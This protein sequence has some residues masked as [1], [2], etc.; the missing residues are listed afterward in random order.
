MVY[1]NHMHEYHPQT[2]S[3]PALQG[4]SQKNIEEH[5]KLYHGYVTHANL[6]TKRIHE[7][8]ERAEDFVYEIAEL[9]RRFGFEYNGMRN[10]EYYFTTFE[11]GAQSFVE[12]S[13]LKQALVE[14][15]GSYEAWLARFKA[16]AKTRGIGWAMLSYDPHSQS[17]VHAWVDE[18]HM[19]QLS[20]TLP[21][22]CLDMWEHAFVADYHPSGKAAYI[23][24][25]FANIN[26]HVIEERYTRAAQSRAQ[27]IDKTYE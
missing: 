3:I 14:T 23:D 1:S 9:Q 16:L 19:G 7:L 18:Q 15:W 8:T 13:K 25:F 2:F 27:A 26:W 10:H 11:G 21:I 17:L 24:D 4:I 5:I 20:T 6:I 12:N 22:L